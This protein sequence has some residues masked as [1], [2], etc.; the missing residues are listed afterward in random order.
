MPQISAPAAITLGYII[1]F[2]NLPLV[3]AQLVIEWRDTETLIIKAVYCLSSSR[4]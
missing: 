2:L 1:A 4:V 3:Q